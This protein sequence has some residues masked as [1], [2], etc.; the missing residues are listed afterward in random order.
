MVDKTRQLI[1]QLLI[2]ERER[3]IKRLADLKVEVDSQRIAQEMAILIHKSD[4]EEEIQRLSGHCLAMAQALAQPGAVGRR[5][6][7]LSQELHREANT[8]SSKALDIS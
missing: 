4:V 3:M 6:D 8:L 5:L 2:A 1:P 7:F